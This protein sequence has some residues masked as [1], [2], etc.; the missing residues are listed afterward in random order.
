MEVSAFQKSTD[1]IRDELGKM[2]R[3][4]GALIEESF[5]AF[6]EGDKV[7]A[8]KVIDKDDQIDAL[9][10]L[11]VDR[12]FDLI[13]AG[14]LPNHD[15][16]SLRGYVRVST[17]LEKMADYGVN[18]AKQT[19]HLKEG[20]RIPAWVPV[21]ELVQTVK[22]GLRKAVDALF[23]KDIEMAQEVCEYEIRLD[24]L[25][26]AGI[27]GLL[28]EVKR[29]GISEE[30]F[31]ITYLFALK[32]SE[33]MGDVLANLGE[34]GVY[35]VLGEKV[36]FHQL[37]HLR[38][39]MEREPFEGMRTLWGGK[40]GARVFLVEQKGPRRHV[41]KE[42]AR[43]KIAEEAKKIEA[44]EKVYPGLVPR[45]MVE[46]YFGDR[47]VLVTEYLQGKT[48]EEIL[49][50]GDK[51]LKK[52]ALVKLLG[53]LRSLW[54]TTLRPKKS[55]TRYVP[56][57]LDRL[58]EVYAYYPELKPFRQFSVNF[59]GMRIP[60]LSE[61]LD[62]ASKLEGSVVAP[63]EV[64]V[65][66]D[67]NSN[68]IFYEDA[69]DSIKFIDVHR[70]GYGDYAQDIATLVVS[71]LRNP[72]LSS[73]FKEEVSFINRSLMR[74][75]QD[76]GQTYGDKDVER[77]LLLALSRVFITSSRVVNQLGLAK[78]L[79]LLGIFHLERFLEWHPH[80]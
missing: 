76:F 29:L 2:A 52:R 13:E 4:V 57:M 39:S 3:M 32:Y 42:G 28:K 41:V 47:E 77:R 11:I 1:L 17:N 50:L 75:A 8:Q 51:A 80:A 45:L 66:G 53:I 64:W 25:Y 63:F 16:L 7:Q 33:N 58:K 48:F 69:T 24:A 14:G 67:F 46:E 44:W 10:V 55:V 38:E 9:N 65:H 62:R 15:M 21:E 18:I 26:E 49:F 70:S 36:K 35:T 27:E 78:R 59:C 54:E 61:L 60:P 40:S 19:L 5:Q 71:N 79:Y 74:F 31:P 22:E 43:Q 34:L 12:C 6:Q 37:L 68:N 20:S 73:Y 30:D 72:L 23:Q 56:Q